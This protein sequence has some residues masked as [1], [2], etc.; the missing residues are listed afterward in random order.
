MNRDGDGDQQPERLAA[1]ERDADPDAFREGVDG[2][3]SDHEERAAGVGAAQHS[4]GH[5]VPLEEPSCERDEDRAAERPGRRA[6]A[7][8]AEPFVQEPGA[9]SEHEAGRERVRD[10]EPRALRSPRERER[11]R[12]KPGRQRRHERGHED[13][14]RAHAVRPPV[15]A[16]GPAARRSVSR[17]PAARTFDRT[18]T[19]PG[20]CSTSRSSAVTSAL[21]ASSPSS[22]TSPSRTVN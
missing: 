4:H 16:Q 12:T 15:A 13:E 18:V 17:R 8:A 14:Q 7:A 9:R 20:T 6:G 1:A 19:T 21:E 11:Q 5:V 2:H 3:D 22:S 10:A